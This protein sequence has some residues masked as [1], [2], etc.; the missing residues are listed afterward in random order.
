MEVAE[1]YPHFSLQSM[2]YLHFVFITAQTNNEQSLSPMKIGL[3]V[4]LYVNI[5]ATMVRIL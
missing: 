5:T 3:L 1:S 4:K 2:T